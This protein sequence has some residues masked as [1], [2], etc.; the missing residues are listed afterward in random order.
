MRAAGSPL[1]RQDRRGSAHRRGPRQ[2]CAARI[3]SLASPGRSKPTRATC[4]GAMPRRGWRTAKPTTP[5]AS[6]SPAAARFPKSRRRGR[7][8]A[9]KTAIA[10]AYPLY[11]TAVVLPAQA[12]TNALARRDGS[13]GAAVDPVI[14]GRLGL[15]IGDSIKIGDASLQLR[16]TI[17]REPDAATSGLIF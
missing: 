14:L 7:W 17:A 12:L 9:P 2:C 6:T 1:G 8:R 11:G 5:N 15:A 16:A 4:W 13:Y 10:A 3:V